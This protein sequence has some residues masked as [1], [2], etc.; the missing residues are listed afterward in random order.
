MIGKVLF[1]D[2]ASD[3]MLQ[4]VDMVCGT[5]GAMVDNHDSTWFE[6]IAD[7]AIAIVQ[8]P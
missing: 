5:V 6:L 8:N 2:S 3:E 7:R 4:L 1:R